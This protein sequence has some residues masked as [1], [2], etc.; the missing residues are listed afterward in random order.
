M[1]LVVALPTLNQGRANAA[2]LLSRSITLSDSGYSG[3]TITTGVG[4]GAAVTYKVAM[5]TSAAGGNVKSLVIDF[6]KEDP[7]ISDTCSAPIGMDTSSA[8]LA[9]VSGGGNITPAN[10]WTPTNTKSRVK[11]A[12][13][14]VAGHEATPGAQ[15]FELSGITNPS[16]LN[17]APTVAGTGTLSSSGT[18]VTGTGTAFTTQ[19]QVGDYIVVGGVA[20]QVTVIASDTSLT[21]STAFSPA[22]SGAGFIYIHPQPTDPKACSYFAR[23]YTF[24]NNTWGTYAS[25]ISVG[26][27]VDY[28]GIA[29]STT[30]IITITARVQ[31]QLTFCVSGS[32]QST[33][34]SHDC[35]DPN[36]NVAPAITLGHGTPTAV[37]DSQNVD[38]A[39]VY[40]QISTNATSGAVITIRNSNTTCGG[41]SADGGATCAIAPINGGSGAGPVAL[42][43]GTGK[44]GL[45]VSA[46]TADTNGVGTVL[47]DPN[48]NDGVNTGAGA[49]AFYAM[50]T[51]TAG[52]N[53]ISTYGDTVASSTAPV[54]RIDNTYTFAA[55]ASLTTPAGIY[56][57]NMALIATGTF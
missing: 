1:L 47:A 12:N 35:T 55:T 15:K 7:I 52:A 40:S 20:K 18:T 30:N 6:C 23:I 41:L 49:A 5:T 31:E 53:V 21:T 16:A 51:T 4:S 26:N 29:L 2:Q 57:A 42:A 43:A 27:F 13:D 45:F 33:W 9:A 44:F 14:N 28:G 8:A 11:L 24:A 19:L 10:N 54:Y 36:A 50:D 37:L 39:S 38:Y 32:V 56:T 25:P 34:A 22:L 46:G 3:G 48:Y 17:C